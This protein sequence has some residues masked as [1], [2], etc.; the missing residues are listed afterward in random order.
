[1]LNTTPGDTFSEQPKQPSPG[2]D[3]MRHQLYLF[4]DPNKAT[5]KGQV[6]S[7]H[8]VKLINVF[9]KKKHYRF[10]QPIKWN[11]PTKQ[12]IIQ[13]TRSFINRK[14]QPDNNPNPKTNLLT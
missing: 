3:N 13:K 2:G 10:S 8:A 1:M 4:W 6:R 9:L 12:P 7:G 11:R 5:K 14:D